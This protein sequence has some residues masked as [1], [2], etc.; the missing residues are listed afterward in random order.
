MLVSGLWLRKPWVRALLVIA[1][2][3]VAILINGVRVFLTGFLVYFVDPAFGQGFMHLS[4]GFAIFLI[5]FVI[6][7]GIAWLLARGEDVMERIGSA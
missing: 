4:E 1:A 5:A 3:P 2:I 6:L 7:A